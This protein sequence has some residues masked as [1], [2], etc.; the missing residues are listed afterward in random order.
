MYGS[1]GGDVVEVRTGQ[2]VYC[3]PGAE[4]WHGATPTD[5]M[6]H[7]AILENADDPAKT[8]TWLE[9]VAEE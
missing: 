7:L 9:H 2:T 6:E 4:P 5:Y 8:T 3:P 1:S